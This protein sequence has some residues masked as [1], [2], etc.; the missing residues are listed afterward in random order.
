[1]KHRTHNSKTK[2]QWVDNKEKA[3][4]SKRT[5]GQGKRFF[6]YPPTLGITVLVK[7]PF[8]K[9]VAP[10]SKEQSGKYMRMFCSSWGLNID[11]ATKTACTSCG[12]DA[13]GFHGD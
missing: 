11:L 12:K 9:V 13:Y 7:C 4:L 3:I 6:E 8:C 1:M 10:L 2:Q 5:I